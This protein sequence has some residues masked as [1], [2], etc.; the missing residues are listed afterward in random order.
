LIADN[1]VFQDGDVALLGKSEKDQDDKRFDRAQSYAERNNPGV[2]VEPVVTPLFAG[3]VS[4]TQMRNFILLG[5]KNSF[6]R[7]LP[8]H[9][10]DEEKEAAFSVVS[11]TNEAFRSAVDRHLDEISTMAAGDVAGA[12][13]GFGPPNKYNPYKRGKTSKPK[14]RRAKRQRRR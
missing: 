10:S 12:G 14:V 3:G 6:K 4:G 1:S 5:D 13:N 9:L 7:N 8:S 2:K 11:Q